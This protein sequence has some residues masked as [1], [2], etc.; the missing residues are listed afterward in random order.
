MVNPSGDRGANNEA[1]QRA[2]KRGAAGRMEAGEAAELLSAI[3]QDQ[4]RSAFAALFKAF[5]PRV[6]SYVLGLGVTAAAADD[7]VQDIMLTVWRRAGLYDAGKASPST[8]IVTIARNRR[9]DLL[10]REKYPQLDPNDPLLVP[11]AEPAA[12]GVIAAAQAGEALHRAI[13]TLPKEQAELLR[14]AYFK[15]QTHS[16]IADSLSLP[17]GT[18]KSRLRLAMA[19]LRAQLEEDF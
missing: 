16:H 2:S 15:D 5:A 12:D 17:L 6:K 18:V 11:A 10:R 4:D 7:L 19:K 13:E 1:S 8:W 3:A 9:I 14:M